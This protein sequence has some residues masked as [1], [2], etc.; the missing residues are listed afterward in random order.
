MENQE[1]VVVILGIMVV[2][3]CV[4]FAE[5]GKSRKKVKIKASSTYDDNKKRAELAKMKVRDLKNLVIEGGNTERIPTRK[6]DLI[7]I[8]LKDWKG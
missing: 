1:I 6:Q 2:L 4:V 3:L 8:A 7:E 5:R